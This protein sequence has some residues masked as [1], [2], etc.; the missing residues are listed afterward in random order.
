MKNGTVDFYSLSYYMTNCVGTDASKDKASGNL[1]VGLKNPYLKASEWGWQ[2]DP[3]GLRWVLNNVY[4][5]YQIPIMI[6]ENGL[7][8]DD[9][10][11]ENNQVNDDYRIE[12]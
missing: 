1:I 11:D 5:R 3:E 7:G 2:V 9:I 12:Y 8:A 10:V 4:D 6:V